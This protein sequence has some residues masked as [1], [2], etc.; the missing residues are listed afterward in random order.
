MRLF[1]ILWTIWLFP[2]VAFSQSCGLFDTIPIPANDQGDVNLLIA[3][4]FN[5]NLA[6]PM[7]GLCGIELHFVHSFSEN[8]EVS[9]TSP[10]GQTIDLIG[11]NTDDAT[12]FTLFT[13]WKISF[14]PCSDT[15]VP[16]PGYLAQWDNN[17]PNNF[18]SGGQYTGSYHPFNGCLEDFNTGVVNGTWTLHF[19]NN[20]SMYVGAILYV[21]L[22]FC[23]SRGVDCCFA[24]SGEFADEDITTCQGDSSLIFPPDVL[25][26][27]TPPDTSEYGYIYAI[28][29]DSFFMAYDTIVDLT[30]Y[31]PG[32]YQ[33][34]GLSY[35]KEDIALLPVLDGTLRLDTLYNQLNSFT[36]PFCGDMT[37]N[38]LTISIAAPLPPTNLNYDLCEGD[39]I[40]IG[41]SLLT[42]AGLHSIHFESI[43]GCDSLVNATITLFET[44]EVALDSVICQGDTVTIGN[45]KYFTSGNYSDTLSTTYLGCDSIVNLSLTVLEPVFY[46]I[47]TTICQ[48]GEFVV[49][50]STF[51]QSGNYQ[52]P[53]TG[54]AGCDSTVLLSL[55]VLTP[56]AVI[57]AP[58][59]LNC[60]HPSIT[61]SGAFSTATG[62]QYEWT[63]SLG[64]NIGTGET[65][66]VDEA[67]SY[68]L[69]ITALDDGIQCTAYDS[70]IVTSN[71]ITPVADAGNNDTL[72]CTKTSIQ[73][74]GNGTSM[75]DGITY[76]WE[77]LAGNLSG[78][79][80][81]PTTYT[82][83]PGSYRLHVLNLASGCSDSSDV[84]ISIDT[85]SPIV[86]LS[87]GF[88]LN[89][90]RVQDTIFTTGS[91]TG[92][93]YTYLWDSPDCNID[94][95]NQPFLEVDCAGSY[96]LSIE[97]TQTGCST[98]DS[99]LI[100]ID[101]ILPMAIITQMDTL[102]CIRQ[103]IQLSGSE[104][105]PTSVTYNWS[106][107]G[108]IGD[109]T[110]DFVTIN[111]GGDYQ[112]MVTNPINY[113]R[114]SMSVSIMMDTLAPIADAGISR[115]VTCSTPIVTLGGPSTSVGA[116]YEY[117][118]YTLTGE[119]PGITTE[120]TLEVDTNGLFYLEV[121]NTVNGCRDTSA[122]TVFIDKEAPFVNAGN[123][124]EFNCGDDTLHLVGAIAN[125]P[126]ATLSHF[127]SGPC[128][129]SDPTELEIDI[130]CSGT[131][132]LDLTN[133][134]TGCS[135]TDSVLI[136]VNPAA[137]FAVLPDT[138]YISCDTGE[139]LID[140]SNSSQAILS[141]FYEGN[142]ISLIGLTPTVTEVG[143][144]Q[145][146]V[147]NLINTCIDTA[148]TQVVFDCSLDVSLTT[149]PDT[150][151]CERAIVTISTTATPASSA[152]EYVWSAMD[153][154]CIRSGQGTP[155][156]E[157]LCPGIYTL[158]VTNTNTAVSDTLNVPI[159]KDDVA[160]IAEAGV[161]DTIT[162]I[163]T[164]AELDGSQ[165]SQGS[166]IVYFWTSTTTGDTIG[167][168]P[169]LS[170]ITLPGTYLLE[171]T[172]TTNHCT[173][174]D[175]AQVFK[176]DADITLAFGS[177][178]IPCMQDSFNLEVFATPLSD[179]YI[180]DWQ[181]PSFVSPS[182]SSSIL[183]DSVGLYS[184]MATNTQSGCTQSA[185]VVVSRQ[186]CTPCVSILK[187]D[188]ISCE[189]EEI[190]L[191]LE[192]CEDC[193][194]CTFVWD[195]SDGNILSGQNTTSITINQAGNYSVT[196]TD[197]SGFNT[198]KSVLVLADT[199]PPPLSFSTSP[200]HLTCLIDS[201][202]IGTAYTSGYTYEWQSLENTP[203]AS[204]T[205]SS[206]A[207][208]NQ[209][210]IYTLE[211]TN[212][213]NGCAAKDSITVLADTI[214][215]VADAGVDMTKTCDIQFVILDG[216]NSTQEP[217]ITYFWES[218]QGAS[219][220]LSGE[221]TISP[222]V[223][224]GGLYTL[225]VEDT[226]TGCRDSDEISVILAEDIPAINPIDDV[227]LDCNTPEVIVSGNTPNE[228]D[229]I[230][231]WCEMENDQVIEGS[232]QSTIDYSINHAG[233]YQFEIID[234]TTGCTNRAIIGATLDSLSPVIMIPDQ[235]SISCNEGGISLAV[236][237][238]PNDLDV[239]I[240]WTNEAGLPIENSQSLTPTI[241][242][243]GVYY[244][245][246]EN[247]ENGC[248]SIDSVIIV[249]NAEK[250]MIN[251][252]QD[253][254]LNCSH[255][256]IRLGGT[257]EDSVTNFTVT[258]QDQNGDTITEGNTLS[259]LVSQI[260]VY[261]L[262]VTNLENNCFNTDT[263]V[264]NANM[265]PP[266][267]EIEGMDT[268]MLDCQV[269]SLPLDGS[270]STSEGGTLAYTWSVENG[271]HII[272]NPN[273]AQIAA[274]QP[275]DYHL[276]VT[277]Q[278]NG[279]MDTTTV[280]VISNED[281]PTISYLPPNLITCI[282][283][284]SIIDASASSQGAEFSSIWSNEA[285]EE[286]LVD[287]LV[288]ETSEAGIYQ[289][290]IINM[291]NHCS[292]V[293]DTIMVRIDTIAPEVDIMLPERLNCQQMEVLLDGSNSS[294]SGLLE[295]QWSTS[296]G[297]LLSETTTSQTIAGMA[298]EYQLLVI[299]QTNG[300][301]DS[302]SVLVEEDNSLLQNL[303]YEIIHPGCIG[304]VSTGR[305]NLGEVTGG[306]APFH[307]TLDD[308]AVQEN[309]T[310][311]QLAIGSHHLFVEDVN[312]CTWGDDFEI[313]PA[314]ILLLTLGKDTTITLGDSIVL[315][316]QTNR[317]EYLD[318]IV[319]TSGDPAFHNGGLITQTVAPE[320]T[321]AYYVWVMDSLG[322]TAQDVILIN[323]VKPRKYFIPNVFTPNGD[324]VNDRAMVFGGKEV[325][326][327]LL[328]QI[329]D[330]W[331]NMVHQ[332]KDFI[333]GN[334][335]DGWDGTLDGKAL[336]AAV[337]VYQVKIK[338]IDGWEEFKTGE[339]ILMR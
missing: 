47:D 75:G 195:T 339:I 40:T 197:L 270:P 143:T 312:G 283:P 152:L 230:F 244:I 51:T 81:M 20:P 84:S 239:N 21:R 178:I 116:I 122:V 135:N 257:I 72:T 301:R 335:E 193:E 154:N 203:F 223:T 166:S 36:A 250:P 263:V 161:N 202:T 271:G 269:E 101:T 125:L 108:I 280:F 231:S 22:Y 149:Q 261:T 199:L 117:N 112:L 121:L 183:V 17:Q 189:R 224:C 248:V 292:T 46:N 334:P 307:I 279:C 333:P 338:F 272:G 30:G 204:P 79:T 12:A 150:L 332:A 245:S 243:A 87:P 139:A 260:G 191:T 205:D 3:D 26:S 229:F 316:A 69:T 294:P 221:T 286:L 222:I 91:S 168:T 303:S 288:L 44:Q 103:S 173:S 55:N 130:D 6:D 266:S 148:Q 35:K 235:D 208:V 126:D 7:Q 289:L 4:Y 118:W 215:P 290:E 253:T 39:T 109:N 172:D 97:N 319:W 259:P 157:V 132:Y 86:N 94:L 217:N 43:I 48:G 37:T 194:G 275:G 70:T 336:N 61:L 33:V 181:G 107:N 146:V 311:E 145:L 129:A 218:E 164:I 177:S 196:V 10:A 267:A 220:I 207:I 225:T 110:N 287:N 213:A 78:G 302:T 252:G 123:P 42:T 83:A 293:V 29:Q 58:D 241:F 232:C 119:L 310:I 323:I 262:S 136:G 105:L 322:C 313:R 304:D 274:N 27:N 85:L 297:H 50:D 111:E 216:S 331:G 179:F 255:P 76:H 124:L 24:D 249:S 138:T 325:E 256:Q 284:S 251:A 295:Y 93:Q 327:I 88:T 53:L 318:S 182:D 299:N 66:I 184:V 285:G 99:I 170:N 162:C 169:M 92:S 328:F 128:I 185:S 113:C 68:Y 247:Q 100:T 56:D 155:T 133:E 321:T 82:E 80:D 95:D 233:M 180:F 73:L 141:W 308:F 106:G 324:G 38:C 8:L 273:D 32:E 165:S 153:E 246:L 306:T 160:P 63:N 238:L 114:D 298:G 326:K 228:T 240:N 163:Q 227:T 159:F 64:T 11:P 74:G 291:T 151:N 144:Y 134:D 158:I 264:V 258:W 211:V 31:A 188:T 140:G 41:D 171:V 16:D 147:S 187:P 320:V 206:I 309:T 281:Y 52:I 71:F 1:L 282:Q 236:N 18:V 104:S 176:N 175:Q 174:Y 329:F 276:I 90:Q 142:P 120:N 190:A 9:L 330:R 102:N 209:A 127:W 200:Q 212:P 54:T 115:T 65:V 226:L 62:I 277:D 201:L 19:N 167:T 214:P 234:T 314:E 156:V 5:D 45:R 278:S 317:N 34:C 315:L 300:C 192:F 186:D 210:G 337:F 96:S 2:M 98:I 25:F 219:C 268:L 89:C 28:A 237:Y 242:N 67:G 59:T 137:L 131:Y 14:V 305:I 49:S 57:S 23:D 77:V 60:Y 254:T 296:N 13:K 265:V 198:I 15:P